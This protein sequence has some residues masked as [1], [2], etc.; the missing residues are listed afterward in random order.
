MGLLEK[1]VGVQNC[2]LARQV[3]LPGLQGKVFRNTLQ[4]LLRSERWTG[5]EHERYQLEKT[6]Q[7]L[8]HC[9]D[10]VP[11]Y[12]NS[13]DRLK[14]HP[15]DFKSLA[16]LRALPM[17]D[18]M[19]VEENLKDLVARNISQRR[20]RYYTTGGST[21]IPMGFYLDR[22]YT[23]AARN[24]FFCR[25]WGWIG[26]RD[27][28]RGVIVRGAVIKSKD[29]VPQKRSL[30]DNKLYVSSYNLKEECI[31]AVHDLLLRYRPVS[32]QAYPSA[33][34]QIAQVMIEKQLPPVPS[35]RVILCGSEN[36][37]AWQRELLQRAFGCRIFSWYGHSEN[38]LL[39]GECEKGSEY[40]CFSEHGV[41]ELVRPDGSV[42][43][44]ANEVGEIVGTGFINDAMPFVRYRTGDMA[45]YAEGPC[46]C[47]RAYRRFSRI[48]GRLQ[49][50]M[51]TADGRYI[52][53]T[54]IN[55]HSDL[56][57]NVKQFQFVQDVPGKIEMRIIRKPSYTDRDSVRILQE[58]KHKMG[59]DM[60]VDL[61]FVDDIPL[62]ARG[63][64]RFLL[65]H[66]NVQFTD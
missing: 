22:N 53:M 39:A 17:L 14:F 10:D 50:L 32:I 13:F 47:G 64:H 61:V 24:A 27:Y 11:Y 28:E 63:K 9:Y 49:E 23:D 35:L 41:F 18:K 66:L 3:S 40:H 44:N 20:L 12:R 52:S 36:L 38:V 26:Y 8:Q 43:E 54:A 46:P 60:A 45:S 2:E 42:I 37:Y 15:S 51:V 30:L 55:M 16:D 19:A 29:P 33:I 25:M 56:F 34:T 65:Q 6:R 57:D 1:W 59:Q 7:L 31:P 5:N 62:T 58:M 4:F 21:G 48:E